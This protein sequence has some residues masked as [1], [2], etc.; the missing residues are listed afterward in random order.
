M[1]ELTEEIIED[2]EVKSLERCLPGEGPKD[3]KYR[4]LIRI[5]DEDFA[6][7]VLSK[8]SLGTA[9]EDLV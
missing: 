6:I 4:M 5:E 2:F 8:H 1:E 9:A 3:A 7:D